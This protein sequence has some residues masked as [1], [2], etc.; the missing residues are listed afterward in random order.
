MSVLFQIS[1]I[2]E[3]DAQLKEA[4]QKQKEIVLH[5]EMLAQKLEEITRVTKAKDETI[6]ALKEQIISD[7]RI[8]S[9]LKAGLT[10]QTELV[11]RNEYLK[12]DKDKLSKLSSYKDTLITQYQNV[13]ML[14]FFY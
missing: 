13:I 4:D 1:L 5:A 3:R 7:E 2:R 9:N 12:M 14:V 6:S 8:I 11:R 10:T